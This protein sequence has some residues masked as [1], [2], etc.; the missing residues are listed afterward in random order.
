MYKETQKDNG[1]FSKVYNLEKSTLLYTKSDH[2]KIR[3]K[4]QASKYT[5]NN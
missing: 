1:D 4:Q 3:N 5:K 2:S